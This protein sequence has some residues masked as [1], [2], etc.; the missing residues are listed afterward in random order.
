MSCLT[1]ASLLCLTLS[2]TAQANVDVDSIPVR[3]VA[4]VSEYTRLFNLM[5]SQD[6]V[7]LYNRYMY[8]IV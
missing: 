1:R 8:L 4:S 2:D 6:E 5:Q 7:R 3:L